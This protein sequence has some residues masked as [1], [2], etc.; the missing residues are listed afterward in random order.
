[1]NEELIELR[2]ARA[3]SWGKSCCL[4]I[5]HFKVIGVT[6]AVTF[7]GDDDGVSEGSHGV[8]FAG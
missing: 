1:M 3:F 2:P 6:G 7:G 4:G 5:K 8:R